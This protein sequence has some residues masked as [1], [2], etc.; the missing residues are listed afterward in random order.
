MQAR[1]SRTSA[2]SNTARQKLTSSRRFCKLTRRSDSEASSTGDPR[3]GQRPCLFVSPAMKGSVLVSAN[4]L[5]DTYP[6]TSALPIASLARGI[7]GVSCNVSL[8]D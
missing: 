1:G 6:F 3:E 2:S 4:R 7:L 5:P 8:V